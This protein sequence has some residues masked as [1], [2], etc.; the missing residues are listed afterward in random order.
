MLSRLDA[1]A[2]CGFKVVKGICFTD[3]IGE[4]TEVDSVWIA[5]GLKAVSMMLFIDSPV[6]RRRHFRRQIVHRVKLHPRPVGKDGKGPFGFGIVSKAGLSIAA[7]PDA[8]I[9]V[10]PAKSEDLRIIG[11]ETVA[12]SFCFGKIESRSLDRADLAGRGTGFVVGG[13]EVR[14][15]LD[16]LVVDYA[17]AMTG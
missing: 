14:F 15:D 8:E 5:L 2:K 6:F 11:S 10:K 17:A 7:F 13:K 16:L 9:V 4:M 12:H 3:R 1:E